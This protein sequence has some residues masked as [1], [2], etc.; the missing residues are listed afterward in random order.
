[1]N[2]QAHVSAPRLGGARPSNCWESL[3]RF[4]GESGGEEEEDGPPSVLRQWERKPSSSDSLCAVRQAGREDTGFC[5]VGPAT[6][7]SITTLLL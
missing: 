1:M 6:T 3:K 2:T 4:G 5:P 7:P